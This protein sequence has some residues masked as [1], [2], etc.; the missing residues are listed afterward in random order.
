MS[1]E[2]ARRVIELF[3]RVRP[4]GK[5]DYDRPGRIEFEYGRLCTTL[6]SAKRRRH[7]LRGGWRPGGQDL[8]D[9]EQLQAIL[10]A[11]KKSEDD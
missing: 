1:P 11:K 5:A 4:P 6:Q 10:L 3:R 2:V 9:I 8:A 7:P